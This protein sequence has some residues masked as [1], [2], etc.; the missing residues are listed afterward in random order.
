M[1]VIN[2]KFVFRFCSEISSISSFLKH[3]WNSGTCPFIHI[4][5][6]RIISK[7]FLQLCSHAAQIAS[8]R[9]TFFETCRQ[10]GQWASAA[11]RLVASS[12]VLH[13]NSERAYKLARNLPVARSFYISDYKSPKTKWSTGTD[14][15]NTRLSCKTCTIG[16][17][18][19]RF[20]AAEM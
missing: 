20:M 14:V 7:Y 11:R 9:K 10:S 1:L 18:A 2:M 6:G 8:Y 17:A 15:V 19:R 5:Y 4:A 12:L 16:Y 3:F 13:R